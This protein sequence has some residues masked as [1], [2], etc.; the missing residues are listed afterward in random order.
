LVREILDLKQRYPGVTRS[1]RNA[2]HSGNEFL[3]HKNEHVAWLLG[4]VIKFAQH[5]VGRYYQNWATSELRLVSAW[6]NVLE[7]G[8]W[9]APH[10]HFPCHWSGVFYVSVGATGTGLDDPSGLI[11]FLNPTPWLSAINQSG[12]FV[13]VPKDGLMF[14]FPSSIYHFVHPNFTSNQRISIAFNLEVHPKSSSDFIANL[15]RP[16]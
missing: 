9:N 4:K 6:A 1:N 15:S 14:L 12:N 3:E 7:K 10:H 11:E 16:Y 13:C 2:W 5:A 8:G